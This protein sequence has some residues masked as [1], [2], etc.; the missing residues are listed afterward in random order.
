MPLIG[1]L[2]RRGIVPTWGAAALLVWLGLAAPEARAACGDYVT[3]VRPGDHLAP[4]Q[5]RPGRPATPGCHGPGCSAPPVQA[6]P[7]AAPKL[8]ERPSPD[9]TADDVRPA[10]DSPARAARGPASRLSPIPLPADILD[11]PRAG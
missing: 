3:V 10:S 7:I 9:L 6:G 8:I 4:D 5:T 11:P 2:I 1:R